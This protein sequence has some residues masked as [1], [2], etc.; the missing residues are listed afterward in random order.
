MAVWKC[1][2]CGATVETRCKPRKCK[3]CGSTEGFEKQV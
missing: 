1:V 3:N 2:K